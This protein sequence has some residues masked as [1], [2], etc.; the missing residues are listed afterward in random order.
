MSFFWADYV[1][2]DISGFDTALSRHFL[3]G[4]EKATPHQQAFNDRFCLFSSIKVSNYALETEERLGKLVEVVLAEIQ[5]TREAINAADKEVLLRVLAGEDIKGQTES[6][7]SIKFGTRPN[8][9][10]KKAGLAI[11]TGDMPPA[12]L[13]AES[14]IKTPAVRV[15]SSP[16]VAKH[17]TAETKGLIDT[18]MD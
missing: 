17:S 13:L 9:P 6:A 14:S 10:E 12:L 18:V 11:E 5:H 7:R 2:D 16:P 8:T 15:V 4:F 3:E 1:Q